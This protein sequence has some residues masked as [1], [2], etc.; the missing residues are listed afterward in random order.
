VE[1]GGMVPGAGG[2]WE[3][4]QA[5]RWAMSAGK[6][7]ASSWNKATDLGNAQ[8]SV[9]GP[10]A[11]RCPPAVFRRVT[12]TVLGSARL[13]ILGGQHSYKVVRRVGPWTRSPPG[14]GRV[15]RMCSRVAQRR[16]HDEGTGRWSSGSS[17][18]TP[19][20]RGLFSRRATRCVRE[21]LLAGQVRRAGVPE[22]R[23]VVYGR[24]RTLSFPAG[25]TPHGA[26]LWL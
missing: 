20:S 3:T 16:N 15:A 11:D 5:L 18:Y 24:S 7:S 1:S 9:A 10:L 26:P 14:A 13:R 25:G 22:V 23:T 2:G 4:H 8:G 21:A 6:P 17:G 19:R 12:V